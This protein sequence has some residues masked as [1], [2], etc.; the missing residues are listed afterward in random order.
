MVSV[1][2]FQWERR[3]KKKLRKS[4]TNKVRSVPIKNPNYRIG[5]FLKTDLVALTGP[6]GPDATAGVVQHRVMCCC[7][8]YVAVQG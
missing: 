7:P 3:R 8:R 5:W 2:V 6:G 1:D 4:D